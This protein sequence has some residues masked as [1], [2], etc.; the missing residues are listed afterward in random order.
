MP[1][2][3]R[4]MSDLK[5]E[6]LAK[7]EEKFQDFK[8]SLIAEI[9]EQIKKEVSETLDKEIEKRKELE[10][11]V[12]MLQEHVKLYQKQM[13]ELKD[14]HD[15][16][17]QYGRRLCVRT[18]GVPSIENE[19][20]NDVFENVKGLIEESKS[21]IPEVAID[22]AHRIGKEY[23]DSTSG[24]KCKSIIVR[25]TTFRHRNM[26]YHG[27]KNLKHT[28]KVKLDLTKKRYSIFSDAIKLSKNFE[29]VNFVMVDINCRLKVVFKNGSS[30]FFSD[31]DNLREILNMDR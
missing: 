27:R 23:T 20:S 10:S 30:K 25:F 19:T 26:F 4:K 5:E 16:L 29:N 6:I 7:I 14:K 17:E 12:S 21:V 9:R 15:D 3:T 1:V 13:N 28:V 22:R 8:S 2:I 11:T 31:C 24:K 18:D